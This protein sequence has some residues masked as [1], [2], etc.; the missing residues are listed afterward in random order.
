[1]STTRATVLL[2][3]PFTILLLT[4]I[5]FGAAVAAAA[6]PPDAKPAKANYG[7]PGSRH[8]DAASFQ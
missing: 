1:M 3:L 8:G 4:G 2:V 7:R 5:V 6:Q